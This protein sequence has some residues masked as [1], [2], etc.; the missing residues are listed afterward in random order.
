[1]KSP[2]TDGCFASRYFSARLRSFEKPDPH[3]T[4]RVKVD[5]R[6]GGRRHPFHPSTLVSWGGRGDRRS[7]RRTLRHPTKGEKIQAVDRPGE[8]SKEWKTSEDWRTFGLTKFG[9]SR[10]SPGHATKRPFI[11]IPFH[12][13]LRGATIRRV[14]II[15]FLLLL[16]FAAGAQNRKVDSLRVLIS[17]E[18]DP[19]RR[20]DHK[21]QLVFTFNEVNLDSS[22]VLAN[23]VAEEAVKLGY[24]KGEADALRAT[25]AALM[26]RSD[27]E[28]AR[29]KLDRAMAIYQVL[30]DSNALAATYRS[31]GIYY[32]MQSEY[33]T[34]N[35]YFEM[36]LHLYEDLK[37]TARM[38]TCYGNL[39]IGYQMRSNFAQALI[40]QQ[41]ALNIAESQ[42]SIGDQAH[43]LLNMGQTYFKMGD[44]LRGE[45]SILKSIDLAEKAQIKIVEVYGYTNLATYY[46]TFKRW[47]QSYEYAMKAA[48]LGDE[49]GDKSI[50]ASSYAK[51]AIALSVMGRPD[52]AI[53]LLERAL[54]QAKLSGQPIII[55][56]VY[57]G[58]GSTLM[59]QGKYREAAVKLEKALDVIEDLKLYDDATSY[60]YKNLSLVYEDLDEF[61]KALDNYKIYATMRDSIRSH[62]NIRKATEQALTFEF[63]KTRAEAIALQAVKDAETKRARSRQYFVIALLGLGLLAVVVMAWMQYRSN[64]HKQKANLLLQS[65]KQ[66]VENTLAELKATQVQLIQ[67]EKMAGLGE[68][69]AGIAHEIQNP[70]NF[71]NNFS[72]VS[73]EL[74]E[75]M[76]LEMDVGHGVEAKMLADSVIDNLEKIHHHGR[77]ADSIVKGMLMHTRSGSGTREPTDL[78]LLADEYLRLAF[79]GLRAKDKSFNAAIKSEFDPSV[80]KVNVVPQDMGRVV[81]NLITNAFYAVSHKNGRGDEN[82]KPEVEVR[83]S[84]IDDEIELSVRDNGDGIAQHNLK[85]IFQPF[86]TTKPTGQGT[87]LGLSLSFD[88]VKAHGGTL[89]VETREGEG[90]VFTLK[91][92]SLSINNQT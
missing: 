61:E 8:P 77:R 32:G 78:N 46:S 71:V 29:E 69:T 44:S 11:S 74:L 7:P 92:R 5:L 30:N 57:A 45:K 35:T 24:E 53:T 56:Q 70:L 25:A 51:A 49:L 89:T 59:K 13:F 33:D 66:K 72:E 48:K 3:C 17:K 65:Q 1:M 2:L 50:V 91:F 42:N 68:L 86:F 15:F 88:I 26:R 62:E 10:V 9:E 80:G 36:A 6:E 60:I 87:G 41:K 67:S 18:K 64:Q 12:P 43:V 81:L 73:R 22:I 4:S 38:G 37:D 40:Y 16:G 39:A 19:E 83:T 55:H 54:P 79:H 28:L 14:Q 82:Y 85:K 84:R 21:V 90:S 20:I 27:F 76:K 75:E 58:F 47:P 23:R 34:A 63:E 31:Y 52:E